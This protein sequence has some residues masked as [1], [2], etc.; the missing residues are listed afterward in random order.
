MGPVLC[1]SQEEVLPDPDRTGLGLSGDFVDGSCVAW[2][3]SGYNFNL[4]L[5]KFK[6]A[7]IL[8]FLKLFFVLIEQCLSYL[9]TIFYFIYIEIQCAFHIILYSF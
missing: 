5:T 1:S 4:E 3:S 7:T 8:F 6:N 2:K 9:K